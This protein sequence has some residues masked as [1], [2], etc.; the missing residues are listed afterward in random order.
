MQVLF[1]LASAQ[2]HATFSYAKGCIYISVDNIVQRSTAGRNKDTRP[3]MRIGNMT[4]STEKKKKERTV[5][6]T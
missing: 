1:S 5:E 6:E 4:D 2:S 3:D